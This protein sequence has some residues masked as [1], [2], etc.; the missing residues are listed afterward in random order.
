MDLLRQSVTNEQE[1]IEVMKLL[2]NLDVIILNSEEELKSMKEKLEQGKKL[3]ELAE[4]NL[5]NYT[6]IQQE[7][8]NDYKLNT[9]YGNVSQRKTNSWIYKDEKR[10]VA[11]LKYI[12]PKLVR[13]KEEIDKVAFKKA[14][15]VVDGQIYNPITDEYFDGV[16]VEEKISYS[17]NTKSKEV[18]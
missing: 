4:Y 14:Y 16:E 11:Q 9:E 3:R 15:D 5:I 12:N 17:V 18:V 1:A 7:L 8:D 10:L 13:I 6:K 2:S